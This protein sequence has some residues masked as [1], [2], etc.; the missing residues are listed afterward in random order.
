M[1]PVLYQI[2]TDFAIALEKFMGKHFYLGIL[3]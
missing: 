1:Y 2:Y 3:P